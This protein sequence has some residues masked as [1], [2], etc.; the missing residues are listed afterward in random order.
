MCA[1]HPSGCVVLGHL[2]GDWVGLGPQFLI[3]AQRWRDDYW[4]LRITALPLH[5]PSYLNC[6]PSP[7]APLPCLPLLLLVGVPVAG[8]DK[9]VLLVCVLWV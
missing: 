8:G 5:L 3:D 4:A 2:V 9:L 6:P 1:R 7:P